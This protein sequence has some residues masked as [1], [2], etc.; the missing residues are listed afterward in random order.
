MS[1]KFLSSGGDIN[2]SNGSQTLFGATIGAVNLNPSAPIKTNS[3]REIVSE[4]LDIGDI[5]NL[6]DDLKIKQNLSFV[7]NDSQTNPDTNQIK[8]YAKTD[9]NLYKRDSDGN[10]TGLGGGGGGLNYTPG[11]TIVENGLIFTDGVSNT[12]VKNVAGFRLDTTNNTLVVNDVETAN[13]LSIDTLLTNINYFPLTGITR[14]DGELDVDKIKNT[15]H[16][17]EIEFENTGALTLTCDNVI[18]ITSTN[19]N[20][21]CNAN[22]YLSVKNSTDNNNIRF[23][24]TPNNEI[25]FYETTT[26]KGG[27]KMGS[28]GVGTDMEITADTLSVKRLDG[29]GDF[30]RVWSEGNYTSFEL[31]DGTQLTTIARF[32]SNGGVGNRNTFNIQSFNVPNVSDGKINILANNEINITS[33]DYIFISAGQEVLCNQIPISPTALTNKSYVDE[34]IAT[35]DTTDLITKTQNIDLTETTS[36]KTRMTQPLELGNLNFIRSWKQ[37][38]NFGDITL[39]APLTA[40]WHFNFTQSGTI[41][42][43]NLRKDLVAGHRT[44]YFDSISEVNNSAFPGQQ[45][46]TTNQEDG[47]YY[48]YNLPTPIPVAPALN[49]VRYLVSVFLQTGDKLSTTTTPNDE[50]LTGVYSRFNNTQTGWTYPN[51]LESPDDCN[52]ISFNF[53]PTNDVGSQ[54]LKAFNSYTQNCYVNN[55]VI[56]EKNE[57]GFTDNN[58]LVSKSYVN[59]HTKNLFI[60]ATD[61]VNSITT[62]GEKM[63]I[64]APYNVI[65][66]KIKVMINSVGGAGFQTII[67]RNGTTLDTA[68]F[69]ATDTFIGTTLQYPLTI[70]ENDIIS[71]EV[72]NTGANTASGLKFYLGCD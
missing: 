20:I 49:N 15:A 21:I 9:G 52:I 23:N 30:F 72:S 18:N 37:Y 51:S 29:T 69:S 58:E 71:I 45:S 56:V 35:I 17:A 6:T 13:H 8:I 26:K 25:G 62:T 34:Q 67:K 48:Y 42:R 39:V 59:T 54:N 28:T 31:K 32:D 33:P 24:T 11:S 47:T 7:K 41:T 10:E 66:K 60:A 55:R 50:I 4:K 68:I 40:G 22:D 65:I 38:G 43:F 57:Y 61:E 27:I 3:V 2:L 63:R 46:F 70:L 5:N 36:T 19:D 14:I 12:D 16:T 44:I 53:N 64:Y 1:N